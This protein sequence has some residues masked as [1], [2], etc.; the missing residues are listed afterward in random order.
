[1]NNK[2]RFIFYSSPEHWLQTSLELNENGWDS[3]FK[4]EKLNMKPGEFTFVIN[5]F[6]KER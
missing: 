4:N 2:E 6:F 5:L 1:L 3:G